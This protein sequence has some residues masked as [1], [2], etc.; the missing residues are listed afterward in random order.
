MSTVKIFKKGEVLFKEGDKVSNVFLIQSGSVSL[1]LTR[2][3]QQ[4]DLCVLGS[5]TIAG[6]HALAGILTHP[7]SAVCMMETKA[8]ELPVEAVR[9]QVEG[10][11]QLVKF[12][13][14]GM[15]DK[16]KIVMKELQSMKLE[17]D[18]T[19]CPADQT[20]KIFGALFHVVRSKGETKTE[21]TITA[22]WP[23]VKQYAQRV[24][25]ESPKRLEQAANVFVKL[26]VAKY[27]WVKN[28]EDPEAPEEIG[29]IHFT[30]LALVEQFFEFFQYYYFKGGKTELL[31]TDERVM[32]ITATLLE[33]AQGEQLDRHGAARL[34]Y[35]K[36]L[37]KFKSAMSLQLNNDH[38][39]LIEQKGL[40][41]KRQSTDTGI[42]L[43]FDYREFDNTLKVWRVLR[44]VERW[45]EKGSVD[46]NEAIVDSRK[47][48]KAGPEC[49]QCHAPYEGTPKFCSE[50]GAKISQ[51]A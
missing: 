18:N 45:N 20:A 48:H 23:L 28:E 24:F 50:C 51:A 25:L 39:A 21:G 43:H 47:V 36:V 15:S 42:V 38:F 14:K 8:I 33:A 2:Q 29:F 3:K 13:T 11:T 6:E 46:P 27:E 7:H 26:G 17:R 19:P 49:A 37:E 9:V 5:N 16:L 44:E 22:S 41:V 34:E 35:S 32:Q 31:K 1:H 40:F 12:L 4:I 10:G 30:D